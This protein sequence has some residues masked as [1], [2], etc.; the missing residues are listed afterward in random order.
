MVFCQHSKPNYLVLDFNWE[1][2]EGKCTIDLVI[3]MVS[4]PA[5]IVAGR[6][7]NIG[8]SNT[9]G[10]HSFRTNNSKGMIS[11]IASANSCTG[12][13]N[14]DSERGIHVVASVN[15]CTEV[16]RSH[17]YNYFSG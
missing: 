1:T 2:L 6:E 14:D 16:I 8:L 12:P 15:R 13:M 11:V 4:I 5:L 9:V 10:F 7:T 17:C 3:A